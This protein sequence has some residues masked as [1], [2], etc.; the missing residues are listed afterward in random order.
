MGAC[1]PNTP[2]RTVRRCIAG[3]AA[4]ALLPAGAASAQESVLGVPCTT[5]ADG[6]RTCAGDVQHRITSWDGI[7]L[8]ATIT[9]PPV[10]AKRPYPLIVGLHGFAGSKDSSPADPGYA[11]DGYAVLS[12]SARG[13]GM[14]CGLIVSRAS[15]ACLKGWSHLADVRY[16]PR[17]TQ[18]LAGLLADTGLIDGQRIG[19]TG[20]SFGAGQA[21]MLATLKDR[22]VL[23]DYRV[24]PWKSPQGR[25]MA[26]A[27]AA[28][29]WA[30]S[31]LASM[32][33]PNGHDL[34][35]STD[36]DYGVGAAI[37]TPKL[38]YVG[39]LFGAATATGFFAP[40][41][42]DFESDAN[43]WVAN[44]AL[45][46]P[47]TD[48][49]RR[50]V[51]EIDAHHSPYTLEDSLPTAGHEQP[52]PI[53]DNTSWT[54]DLLPPTEQLKYRNRV[55]ARYP[56]AEY[57]L[58]LSDGAGHPRASLTGTTPGLPALQRAF[59]DRLLQ[60]APGKPL[61]IRTYTQG[62]EASTVTGPFDTTSWGAQHPG[63]VVYASTGRHAITQLADPWTGVLDDPVANVASSCITTTATDSPLA[64]TYRLPAAT[65]TGYTIL[66]SPTVIATITAATPNT[67]VNA[68]LWDV[69]PD[70][71]QAFI[72][73]V[74]YRPRLHDRRPQVFQL[75]PNG[76]HVAA[77]HQVKLEL[78]GM[79]APYV[80][81]S[82]APF[83]AT[84]AD[85][86]LRLPVRD[87]PG[88][89]PVTTPLPFL[90]RDGSTL[91]TATLAATAKIAAELTTAPCRS[92]RR[93]TIHLRGLLHAR[94]LVNGRAITVR[95]GRAIVDL[96]GRPSGRVVV[97][98]TGRRA[99][100]RRVTRRQVFHPC[101]GV[102]PR[103]RRATVAVNR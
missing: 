82:N 55:L 28:P 63:E 31:N 84:I 38:S 76:W 88:T 42:T 62:C 8:D 26:I 13:F 33:V 39:L 67:Q 92:A 41:N 19:V 65:G 100:G 9:L 6:V 48:Y 23:P 81:Q 7:P 30:W 93:I 60:G 86:A 74:A 21:V 51:T 72:T 53:F 89:G 58:L 14:S 15:A 79:D 18:Y 16:E 3:V 32:L 35:Y 85:L 54:D 61:G 83:T 11:K 64:A 46:D 10:A 68:R 66:G 4:L 50:V 25:P 91:P 12:Y 95:R 71:R 94:V 69:G 78:V 90:D 5:A 20:T 70:G 17:D 96:R 2:R 44:F 102:D 24:V 103:G 1:R 49:D 101:R 34:D 56:K 27:A 73:R 52:A 47:Y 99:N 59:F 87:Q 29:N 36:N 43:A 77:G 22:T 97:R 40:P 98:I 57:D 37:G 80:R 75:H 45:G